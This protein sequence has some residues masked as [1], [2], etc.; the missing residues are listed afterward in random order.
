MYIFPC[1]SFLRDVFPHTT[2]KET[3]PRNCIYLMC[4]KNWLPPM[5]QQTVPKAAL[6]PVAF[7]SYVKGKEER[8]QSLE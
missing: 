4:W 6:L 5:T 3:F 7:A 1:I 2:V 8:S